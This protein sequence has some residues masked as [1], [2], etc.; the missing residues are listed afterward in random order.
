[1]Y[2]CLPAACRGVGRQA[3]RNAGSKVC[4]TSHIQN[5]VHMYVYMCVYTYI[6]ER[7]KERERERESE[8]ERERERKREIARERS[9]RTSTV[10][11]MMT[12]TSAIPVIV[13]SDERPGLSA[14]QGR[15][16]EGG[17]YHGDGGELGGQWRGD[18]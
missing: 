18:T 17:E 4:S 9:K 2:E 8:R 5:L 14:V 13:C 1:M 7:D 16:G 15:R 11:R 10:T 12:R 3:D 6:I